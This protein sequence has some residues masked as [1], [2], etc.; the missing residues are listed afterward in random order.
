M[1][2]T[3]IQ[4]QSFL[5]SEEVDFQGF[6]LPYMGMAAISINGPWPFEQIVNS[7]LTE[8]STWSLKKIGPVFSEEKSIKCVDG[9]RTT[10][11]ELSDD[12]EQRTASDQNSSSW[13]FGWGEQKIRSTSN[14]IVRTMA[15]K[16][17][18]IILI[19]LFLWK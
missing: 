2:Y 17:T 9:R 3:K 11:D 18:Y 10:T 12:D 16:S 8:V 1:L 19:F 4:P 13:A 15:I 14:V 5:G 6:F 7:S